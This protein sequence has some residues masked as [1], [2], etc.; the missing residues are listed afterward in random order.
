MPEITLFKLST[1]YRNCTDGLVIFPP[2][3]VNA[4]VLSANVSKTVVVPTGARVAV[5]NSTVDFYVNWTTTSIVPSGDIIDGTASELNPIARNVSEF[6][7]F[8]IISSESNI[9]TIAYFS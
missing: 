8:N 4:Y 6:A 5:F 1:D 9:V 7:E 3:Y 2:E